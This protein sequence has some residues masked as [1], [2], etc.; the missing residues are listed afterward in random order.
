MI[1]LYL[2][3]PFC[4]SK[5]PYCDFYSLTGSTDTDKDRYTAA[6]LTALHDWAAHT[7]ETAD[8]VYLGGGTPSL[9]GA[10]RIHTLLKTARDAFHIPETA[11]ITLEANPADNL[12]EVFRGFAAAG[13]NRVSLGVQAVNDDHLKVLGRRH[14]VRDVDSAVLAAHRAGLSNLS[15]DMMLA[16]AGQTAADIHLAVRCFSDWGAKHVSAYLLK[17]ESGTPYALSPPLLPDEDAAAALY[18]ETV[19]ALRENGY[20]QYEISNFAKTGYESR[21]NLKYWN[22]EPY[23]GIGPAAHS[24]IGGK[25]LYYPR[26]VTAFCEGAMPLP[27]TDGASLFAEN[28]PE[29]YA[30]LRF[31]LCEG[32]TEQGFAARFGSAIPAGWRKRAAALPPHLITADEYGIRLTAEGFLVSDAILA[33]IL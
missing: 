9:L 31:R 4:V 22:S 32:L 29:E 28:S 2:H 10:G 20:R 13:G 12:D 14:T 6:L 17:L 1:G 25:R 30:M 11:E 26:S 5:C 23:L 8:T 16:T 21:H 15:L 24:F 3:V 19:E 33:R 18:L 7:G 27:E